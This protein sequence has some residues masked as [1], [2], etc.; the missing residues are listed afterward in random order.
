[1]SAKVHITSEVG[2]LRKVIVHSPGPEL[3]AVTP[4]NRH[5]YLYDDII[6]LRGAREEHGRFVNILRR[7]ADVYEVRQ[8][9]ETTLDLPEARRFLLMRSEEVTADRTL[10]ASMSDVPLDALI[11]RYV[12]G[13]RPPSG[14][15]S[16]KLDK[17]SYVLPPIPNLFFTRDAAMVLGEAVAISAMRFSSRWPEEAL[18]RTV[19]GFHPELA[20]AAVVYDGSDERRYSYS[21]EGGDVHVLRNDLLL[22]GVSERTTVAALDALTT[23]LFE[24]TDVTDVV[25]VVL[26]EMTPAIHLDMVWTQLDRTL[27]AVHPPIFRGPAR[28]PVLHRRRGRQSVGEP[29]DL[30]SALAAL[31]MPL[32]P[33]FCGGMQPEIQE[34]EQ[35]ASGCNFFAVAPGQVLSYARNEATLRSLEEGGFRLLPAD[36]FL[37]DDM[38][39]ADGDRVVLT[40]QGAELVRGGG[41]PRC[42][43]C[44]VWRDDV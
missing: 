10:T 3:L 2:R 34:R 19:F 33:L 31:D 22:I 5:E 16:E 24:R 15:F 21:I 25:A 6:D 28:A 13:W 38:P 40:F 4:S 30:F 18:M 35:W 9:L 26:P 23:A 14:A 29:S 42:M 11:R 1:M 43:T 32:E 37:A 27:C 8:L 41:G 36:T 39:L 12:E 20:G 44:P 7:F 17:A